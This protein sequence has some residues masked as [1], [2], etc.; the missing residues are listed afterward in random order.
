MWLNT[1][2]NNNVGPIAA[3][4]YGFTGAFATW[5]IGNPDFSCRDDGSSGNCDFNPC[6][7]LI[8]NAKGD[9][10]PQ[11]YYIMESLV[12]I[13]TYFTGLREAFTVSAIGAALSKDNWAMTFSKDKDDKSVIALREILNV[14]ATTVAMICVL[15]GLGGIIG[16]SAPGSGR[17]AS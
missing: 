12:G 17:S 6:S 14:L 13:H 5:A 15:S 11:T 8:L 4:V 7:N 9:D 1:W 16:T 2:V 3:N 10:V